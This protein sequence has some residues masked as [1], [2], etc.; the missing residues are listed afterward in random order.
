MDNTPSLA[1][2]CNSGFIGEEWV[3]VPPDG[4]WGWLVLGGTLLINMLIPG[5]IKSFGVLFVEFLEVFETTPVA[6]SWIPALCYFLYC[7]IGPLTTYLSI[8]FSYRA[9]TIAGGL[10]AAF[11][12]ILSC[13][14]TSIAYLYFSFGVMV[15]L[16]A[17]LSFPPGIYLVTSYFVKYRGLA[18]GL[19]ISGSA[20]GSIIFPPFLRLLLENFGY[21]GAVLIMGG[22]TLNVI[23]GA[24]LYEPVEKHMKWIK[25]KKELSNGSSMLNGKDEKSFTEIALPSIQGTEKNGETV[26]IIKPGSKNEQETEQP[27][28]GEPIR[29]M[30]GSGFKK[31]TVNMDNTCLSR[32]VSTCSYGGRMLNGGSSTQISRK[33][34]AYNSPQAIGSTGQI[35][36]NYSVASNM[37]SSSFRYVS[38]AFHGSTLVGLHPEFSSNPNVVQSPKDEYSW[39]KCCRNVEEPKEKEVLQEDKKPSVVLQ[40]LKDPIYIIILISNASNAIGYVNFTILAPSYAVALGFDK[41]KASYLL[42]I[43]ATTDLIG[44]IG[45]AALSDILRFDKRIYFVGGFLVSGIALA[46]LPL[47]SSY[48]FIGAC[49]ALFGLASGTYVGITAVIMVDMLGEELLAS[50]YGISLFVNGILQLIGPPICGIIYQQI[51][52]YSPIVFGLG[53][54]LII[55]AA[56][57]VFVPFL[58]KRSYI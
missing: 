48:T 56:V 32:K 55:G 37:S 1:C 24:L 19:A 18:N 40:L 26:L 21:R 29:K 46:V 50:S 43:I 9:V 51:E 6:A 47:F 11:G 7:S 4:G 28:L 33:I 25:V 39:F 17:G 23:V 42:S 2:G 20:I 45:G 35:A 8:K 27:L 15:G 30:S 58:R 16:G 31:S 41:A 5:T 36:R 52:S 57:W 22:F 12:M 14:A 3:K 53:I 54:V 13:F 38:T 10:S 49:C 44:R 34:S